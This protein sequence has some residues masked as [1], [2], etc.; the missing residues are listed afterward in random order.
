[1]GVSVELIAEV[2]IGDLRS[3]VM[4]GC[5]TRVYVPPGCFMYLRFTLPSVYRG[6]VV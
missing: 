5:K 4:E 2:T 1:M 3:S 6:L